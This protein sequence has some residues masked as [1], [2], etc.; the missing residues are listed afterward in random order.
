MAERLGPDYEPQ[1]DDVLSQPPEA[2]SW[3]DIRRNVIFRLRIATVGLAKSEDIATYM[4][5]IAD[6]LAAEL[7]NR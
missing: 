2:E 5:E 4:Q 1:A 6:D 7:Q 3:S